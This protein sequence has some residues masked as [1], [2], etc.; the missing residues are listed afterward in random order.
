MSKAYTPTPSDSAV[1]VA[2][3]VVISCFGLQFWNCSAT[4][5]RISKEDFQFTAFEQVKPY[6]QRS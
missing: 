1:V 5:N 4:A 2:G 3:L 6:G